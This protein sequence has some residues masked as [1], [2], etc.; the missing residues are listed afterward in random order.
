M[1]DDTFIKPPSSDTFSEAQD[2]VLLDAVGRMCGHERLMDV[3]AVDL[4]MNHKDWVHIAI[5]DFKA[6]KRPTQCKHRLPTLLT[7]IFV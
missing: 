5:N 4:M 6:S 2:T 3:A 7:L 1:L